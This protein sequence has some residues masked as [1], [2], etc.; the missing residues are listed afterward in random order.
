MSEQNKGGDTGDRSGDTTDSKKDTAKSPEELAKIAEDQK[1]R[2]EKAEADKKAAE[3][4]AAEAE[5]RATELEQKLEGKADDAGEVSNE[6]I[7]KIAEQFDVDPKFAEALANA[8]KSDNNAAI[9]KARKDLESELNKQKESNA[10]KEFNDAF[11]AAFT[12]ATEDLPDGTSIDK[13][14]VKT[15]FLERVKNKEDLT[16]SDVVEQM[17]GVKGKGSSE[18]DALGG[19]GNDGGVEIDFETA[20]RDPEKLKAIMANPE[21]KAK[22]YEWRDKNNM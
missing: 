21:A 9:D 3:T 1:K 19:G 20:H 8:I 13:E 4:R 22:Y 18:D 14:A 5:K 11:D 12:K 2:A 6:N 16:V 17:Y 10:Q 15:V 7:V